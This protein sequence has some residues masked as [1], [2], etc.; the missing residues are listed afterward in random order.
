MVQKSYKDACLQVRLCTLRF[1][2]PHK[3]ICTHNKC[4]PWIIVL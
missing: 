3:H 2:K 1:I 4:W